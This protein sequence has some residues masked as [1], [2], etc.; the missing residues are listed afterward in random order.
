[1]LLVSACSPEHGDDD[2]DDDVTGGDAGADAGGLDAGRDAEPGRDSGPLPDGG[3]VEDEVI[4]WAHSSS[5]LYGF[6]PRENTVTT[7]GDFETVGGAMITDMTDLA[8][9]KDGR[10]L[11]CN[12][13]S[14][15]DIDTESAQVA[16]IA[17]FAI[18]KGARFFG[19]TFLPEGVLDDADETLVGA[20]STGAYYRVDAVDGTT[21][22]IGQFSDGFVLSGDI[23]SV[24]GAG[25]YATVKRD[26]LETD[27]LVELDPATGELTRIGTEIGTVSLFGLGYWRSRLFGFSSRGELVEI[28]IDDGTGSTVTADTGTD[29]FW[30]AGVTTIA[31]VGPF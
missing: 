20:T 13:T 30:G 8:V 6:D 12:Y 23:V 25:T 1:V 7:V 26:D 22:L 18:E 10:V 2:D 4:V 19:L 21:E 3:V 15:W 17:D 5:T 31:P 9:D 24:E 14:L 28:D 29:Q 11:G 16:R 27:A